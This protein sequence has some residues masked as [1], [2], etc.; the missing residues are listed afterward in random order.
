M[1]GNILGGKK[2]PT[3]TGA[4]SIG[5]TEVGRREVLKN[6]STGT[7]FQILASLME[8]SPQ[9]VRSLAEDL[10]MEISDFRVKLTVME[11]NKLITINNQGIGA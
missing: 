11:G 6:I 1:F 5:I 7:E 10:N 9:T 3:I 8:R 2:L 4:S